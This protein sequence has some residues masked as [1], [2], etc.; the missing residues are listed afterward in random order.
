MSSTRRLVDRFR[1]TL[2]DAAYLEHAQHRSLPP[3]S[4]DA[5]PR[6][7]ARGLGADLVATSR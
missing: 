6:D 1:L 4:L 5:A 3:A 2:H 7:A